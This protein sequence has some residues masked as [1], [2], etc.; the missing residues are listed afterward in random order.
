MRFLQLHGTKFNILLLMVING[1]QRGVV[2]KKVEQLLSNYPHLESVKEKIE[3]AY[4]LMSHCYEAKR[5]ILLCGNGGSAADCEHIAGELLKNFCL[6]RKIP[7]EE[8]EKFQQYGADDTMIENI[9]G[10]LPAISLVSHASFLT[11]FCNDH[12][13]DNIFAQQVYVLGNHGDVLWAISTSG[14]SSNVINAAI[15]AKVKGIK[16]VAMTG[17]DGGKLKEYADVLINV[18]ADSTARIQEMHIPIYHTICKILE[19]KF[20]CRNE[21]FDTCKNEINNRK[22]YDNVKRTN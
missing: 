13:M 18:P 14:N 21:M 12:G 8:R 20:F 10:G 7:Q 6:S 15:A 2:C 1:K 16:I 17:A 9:M 3:Q 5:K 4:E 19:G 11:A 22:C